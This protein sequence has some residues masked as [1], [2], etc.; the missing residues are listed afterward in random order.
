MMNRRRVQTSDRSHTIEHRRISRR[1]AIGASGAGALALLSGSVFGAEETQRADGGKLVDETR[2]R[3]EQ[4]KA[5]FERLRN[6]GPEDRA[7]IMAED[8]AERQRR[9]IEDLKAQLGISDTDWL[10]VKPRIEAVYNLVHPP[11]QFGPGLPKT[12]VQQ[13]SDELREM[14]HDEKAV[15]DQIRAKLTALRG[16]KEKAN[17]EMVTA[18]QSLRQVMTLRQE[19]Q[20]VLNGLLD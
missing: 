13:R 6:A 4:S 3:V 19:A 9:A 12:E 2:K 5:F 18:R 16:A 1:V 7:K 8:R 20:L 15:P 10:A 14:L 11:Q 17:R